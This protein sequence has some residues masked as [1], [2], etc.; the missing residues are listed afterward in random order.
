M[1]P[2]GGSTSHLKR[3]LPLTLC[4]SCPQLATLWPQHLCWVTLAFGLFRQI[5]W[6]ILDSWGSGL[7]SAVSRE[8]FVPLNRC[9]DWG[10]VSRVVCVVES[11]LPAELRAP[12]RWGAQW[13]AGH[14][15][16]LLSSSGAS[17][18]DHHPTSQV[19]NPVLTH[20]PL[21]SQLLPHIPP[22]VASLVKED[23]NSGTSCLEQ[24]A[25]LVHCM[26]FRFPGFPDLYEP[27]MEA[28]KVSDSPHCSHAPLWQ[29]CQ[30]GLCW[31]PHCRLVAAVHPLALDCLQSSPP[32]HLVLRAPWATCH[33]PRWIFWSWLFWAFV[34]ANHSNLNSSLVLPGSLLLLLRSLLGGYA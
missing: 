30:F 10:R 11:H 20:P 2:W 14:T 32:A 22:M 17:S 34:C 3:L 5:G 28:I 8:L 26:V 1:A 29:R 19:G 21:L 12:R 7:P 4:Q 24:L 15:S 9:W 27:V 33:S 18:V 6:L 13:S 25:E 16:P 23:S 31:R